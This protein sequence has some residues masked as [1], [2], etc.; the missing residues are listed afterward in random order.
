MP[1]STLGLSDA[2]VNALS[3]KGYQ[4]PSPI[5]RQAIPAI[6]NGNDV[7]AAAATGSGKTASFVLPLL[8]Q[9]SN[10]N[11]VRGKRIRS[12][13][14]TPTR[15]LAVQVEENIRQYGKHTGVTSM[16]MYG[17]VDEEPQKQQLIEGVDIVVAT[18]G[19]LLDLLFQRALYFDEL[20]V[21]VL[22]EADRMLDMGFIADINKIIERLPEQRQNLLFSATLSD[23]VRMLAKTTIH[24]PIEISL[25]ASDKDRPQIEQWA[26]TVDKDKKSALLSHL[27]NEQQWQQGLIFIKTKHGAAKLVGQLEKRGIKAEAFHSGRS[28]DS[29]SNLLDDFKSGKLQFLVATGV[30]SRGIDIDELSRVINYDL[31]DEADDYIHR[32]G[33]TGRAGAAGEAISLVSRDDFRSLCAIESRLD[34]LL[35]RRVVEGFTPNKEVP[36]S[37]LN[38][39]PKNRRP[40]Q[41]TQSSHR[42]GEKN[43]A[44]KQGN[45]KR[46]L[47]S[48][49]NPKKPAPGKPNPWNL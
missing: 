3:E 4:T 13:I 21:L 45:K 11:K 1:F 40:Q 32:I 27:I 9:F 24:R 16:A 47:N 2:I 12:L 18:P 43:T 14:L 6:L 5:Q 34:K 37:I 28:Q 42:Q 48:N 35:E 36:V 17:G 15:E 33:R 8:Q 44:S 26:I 39:V 10:C 19:R 31:P 23:Q 22:D 29:R 46:N 49:G 7:I 25:A 38:Y 41:R 20:K 30:A